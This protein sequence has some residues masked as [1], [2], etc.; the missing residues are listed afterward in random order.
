[1]SPPAALLNPAMA[2]RIP[3]PS[4]CCTSEGL[5]SWLQV[6]LLLCSAE[7]QLPQ[8]VTGQP[9]SP[10][11]ICTCHRTPK[12]SPDASKLA[13]HCKY[14]ASCYRAFV[15]V[16]SCR[17]STAIACLLMA[18]RPRCDV[19]LMLHDVLEKP[20][21]LRSMKSAVCT[22][23]LFCGPTS[24]TAAIHNLRKAIA[25]LLYGLADTPQHLLCY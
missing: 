24:S 19:L 10:A 22:G 14:S 5:P 2:R 23:N 6:S 17:S 1:M 9:L 16:L 11:L 7:S 13:L 18:V 25:N 3:P 12:N 4:A 8:E 21:V 20:I 15:V